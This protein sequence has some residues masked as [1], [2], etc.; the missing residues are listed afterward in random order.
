M[1]TEAETFVDR[2]HDG[3]GV[4][5]V[6]PITRG[7]LLAIASFMHERP[8][9]PM[10]HRR[11][12]VGQSKLARRIGKSPR[13]VRM[14]LARLAAQGI[15][16]RTRKAE[17]GSGRRGVQETILIVGFSDQEEIDTAWSIPGTDDHPLTK[18]Q[19]APEQPATAA[20][21]SGNNCG[22]YRETKVITQKDQVREDGPPKIDAIPP[23]PPDYRG[24]EIEWLSPAVPTARLPALILH[25][26]N[27][28]RTYGADALTAALTN[29]QP[30][31]TSGDVRDP[32]S[33]IASA[34][35][36]AVRPSRTSKR[37]SAHPAT[38]KNIDAA[39]LRETIGPKTFAKPSGAL[40][41]IL[42]ANRPR[43]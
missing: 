27:L 30:K 20:A 19:L 43:H 23:I 29:S 38:E 11:C 15:I 32:L 33:Y 35:A 24:R 13:T 1:S 5:Q 39:T 36:N 28:E 16:A 21:P 41:N 42:E 9:S 40:L 18:R 10:S 8:N 12:F 26:W 31:I 2:L 25:L 34:T 17:G 7:T 6:P 14:H 4:G 22:P 37:P 3:T